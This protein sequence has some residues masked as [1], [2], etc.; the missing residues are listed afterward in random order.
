[1]Q[2]PNPQAPAEGNQAVCHLL[3]SWLEKARHGRIDFLALVACEGHD[4][5]LDD[6]AGNPA[7]HFAAFTGLHH[8][9]D[10][11]TSDMVRKPELLHHEE[12][13]ANHVVYD[14]SVEPVS[15]DFLAWLVTAEMVRR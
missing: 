11:L 5:F 6:R 8:L 1:M 2:K 10:R 12:A 3:E 13:P 9:A 7:C 15:Y 14:L 4:A